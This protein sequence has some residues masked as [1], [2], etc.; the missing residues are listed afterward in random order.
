MSVRILLVGLASTLSVSAAHGQDTAQPTNVRTYQADKESVWQDVA[1]YFSMKNIPIK[2]IE[3]S[4]GI[5]SA[6][7]VELHRPRDADWD[8]W[9][10]CPRRNFG[11]T[12]LRILDRS[13]HVRG[14]GDQTQV[15]ANFSFSEVRVTFNVDVVVVPCQS[16]GTLERDL[17]NSISTSATP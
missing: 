14:D 17:L 2:T 16:S 9:A 11:D 10:T 4:T 7:R 12:P 13:V 8:Q 5:I 15:T 3:Y 6:E 1:A